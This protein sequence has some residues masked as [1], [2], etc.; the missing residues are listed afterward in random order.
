M[1]EQPLSARAY[2]SAVRMHETDNRMPRPRLEDFAH[3]DAASAPAAPQAEPAQRTAPDLSPG[4]DAA[5]FDALPEDVRSGVM[6]GAAQLLG[7]NMLEIE[8]EHEL[9]RPSDVHLHLTDTARYV[10]AAGRV[11]REAI[12]G[13]IAKLVRERPELAR[14]G[15]RPGQ[16]PARADDRRRPAPGSMVG[17]GPG[18]VT[19]LDDRTKATLARMQS[20]SGVK[21]Q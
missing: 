9:L 16:E 1:T 14:Y 7:R 3:L 5:A 10:E 11:D 20:A 18:P 4:W 8:A 2:A 13:D 19:T 12:R 17:A 15:N 6:A 21:F